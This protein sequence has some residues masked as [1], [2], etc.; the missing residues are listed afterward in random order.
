MTDQADVEDYFRKIYRENVELKAENERL[1]EENGKLA[2]TLGAE[3]LRLRAA[4]RFAREQIDGN[5]YGRTAGLKK[6][7]EALEE[8]K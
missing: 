8:R 1:F 7:D 6:I 2:N 5:T 3:N 4:L